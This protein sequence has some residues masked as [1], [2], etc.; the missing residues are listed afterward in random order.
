MLWDCWILAEKMSNDVTIFYMTSSSV[1]L[2]FFFFVSFVKFSHWC[3]FHVNII[4]CSGVM[5]IFFY[6]GLNRNP[7]T[8]NT[9][10]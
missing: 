9:P 4:T 5:T 1:F 6:K 7:E 3:K 2:M 8:G 10:A